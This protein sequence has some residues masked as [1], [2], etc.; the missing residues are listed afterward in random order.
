MLILLDLSVHLDLKI[1]ES[2]GI[3]DRDR[4]G[5]GYMGSWYQKM[6]QGDKLLNVVAFMWKGHGGFYS[7]SHTF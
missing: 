1:M 5:L 7:L 4:Q 3:F 6:E 2:L